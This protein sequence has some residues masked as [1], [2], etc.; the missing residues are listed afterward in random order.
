EGAGVQGRA[1]GGAL[2]ALPRPR[3]P[4][5]ARLGLRG[6]APRPHPLP[7][8]LLPHPGDRLGQGSDRGAGDHRSQPLLVPRPLLRRGLPAAQG[9][10][11]GEVAALQAADAVH[12]QPRR[13]L[14][15]PARAPRRR[16]VQDRSRRARARRHRGHVRRGRALALGCSRRAQ[17]RPRTS[18]PRVGSDRRA[19]RD[20]RIGARPQLEEAAVPQGDGPV[21]RS[22]ALRPDRR[23][24]AR[25]VAGGLPA[26]L[27]GDLR[28]LWR[29]AAQRA[30]QGG[31]SGSRRAPGRAQAGRDRV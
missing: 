16:R 27:R 29:A 31:A 6:R 21:R 1:P 14:P 19:D 7:R 28:A 20:L 22:G 18:R 12:L 23:A 15:D 24:L 4:R 5:A 11:P 9:A 25:A 8:P 30:A 10:V 3:A 17:A 26:R 2:Q 13:G